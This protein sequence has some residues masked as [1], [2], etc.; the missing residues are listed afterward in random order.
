MQA[1]QTSPL[2]VRMS[3]IKMHARYLKAAKSSDRGERQ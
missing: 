2:A 3:Y 1:S